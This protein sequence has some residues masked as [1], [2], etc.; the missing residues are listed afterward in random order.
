MSSGLTAVYLKNALDHELVIL[1]LVP[2]AVVT[3]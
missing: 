1:Q 2:S 3:G